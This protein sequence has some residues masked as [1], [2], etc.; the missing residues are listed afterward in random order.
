LSEITPKWE[1]ICQIYG[2]HPTFISRESALAAQIALLT[3]YAE[4]VNR[5]LLKIVKDPHAS[6]DLSQEFQLRLNEGAFLKAGRN[7]F[8]NYIKA[9]LRH[10]ARRHLKGN[11]RR[12]V[13]KQLNPDH[14]PIDPGMPTSG[15]DDEQLAR[16][17]AVVSRAWDSLKRH[18]EGTGK[19]LGHVIR[20]LVEHP[21]LTSE[22]VAKRLSVLLPK[23]ISADW[24]RKFLSVARPKFAGYLRA[25]V[26]ASLDD[27]TEAAVTQELINLGLHVFFRKAR[28]RRPHHGRHHGGPA[29]PALSIVLP[30]GEK[31]QPVRVT[32]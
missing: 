18:Y 28:T 29:K 4:A 26:T 3:D 1:S 7:K 31:N 12:P 24:V 27:P 9:V 8:A 30:A 15:T 6:A 13:E 16:R 23:E 17:G 25:E 10:L 20:L 19:P 11:K 22:E 2:V 5:Y 21:G 14:E 32:I